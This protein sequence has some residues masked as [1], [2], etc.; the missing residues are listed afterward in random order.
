MA[1]V[2]LDTTVDKNPEQTNKDGYQQVENSTPS[3][4]KSDMPGLPDSMQ[5]ERVRIQAM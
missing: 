3:K 1:E 4:G 5:V 2:D